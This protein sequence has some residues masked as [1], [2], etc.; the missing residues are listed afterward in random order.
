MFLCVSLSSACS[1]HTTS[2]IFLFLLDSLSSLGMLSLDTPSMHGDVYGHFL[3]FQKLCN[4]KHYLG[5]G[6]RSPW[7]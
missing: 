2:A 7:Q 5:N 6:F 1:L 3:K 4:L